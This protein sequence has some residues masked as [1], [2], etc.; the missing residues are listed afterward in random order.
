MANP[1]KGEATL[2]IGEGDDAEE[3]TIVIDINALIEAEDASGLDLDQLLD[4]LQRGRSL[5]VQRALLWAGLQAKHPCS[6]GW[7]GNIISLATPGSVHEA[8]TRAV[9]GAFPPAPT[10]PKAKKANPRKAAA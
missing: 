2:K 9:I 5:K 1:L 10:E 7:A 6:I 4:G 3:L 8:L